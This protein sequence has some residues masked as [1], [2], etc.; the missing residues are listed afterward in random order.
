MKRLQA[1]WKT[2]GPVKKSRSEAMWQRFRGAAD[3]FFARFAQRHDIALGERVAAREAICAELEALARQSS[4]EQSSVEG[5]ESAVP[6]P[7][8]AIEEPPADLMATVRALRGR[9]Q[10]EIAARGVDRD[11]ALALDERFA[12]GFA[13]VIERWPAV[14][15]GSDLDPDANRKKMETIVQRVEALAKSIGGPASAAADAALSPTARMAAMLKEALAANTIGGKTDDDSRFRAAADDVRQ[16]QAALSRIGPV[17][18]QVRRALADRFQ[19]A[20]RRIADATAPKATAR[21]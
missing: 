10:S 12:K 17:P 18:D 1:E 8:P 7:Q 19:R 16:A 11:R 2:I 6:N 20:T 14:F 3:H 13:A 21:S 9:W 5:A 15:G 4:V